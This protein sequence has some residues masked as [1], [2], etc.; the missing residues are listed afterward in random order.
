MGTSCDLATSFSNTNKEKFCKL[1]PSTR[2]RGK[3]LL[4]QRFQPELL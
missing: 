3:L 2:T 4:Y 1:L